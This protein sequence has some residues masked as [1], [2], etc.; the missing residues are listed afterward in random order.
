MRKSLFTC[1]LFLG[2][3]SSI[4]SQDLTFK[5]VSVEKFKYQKTNGVSN[6]SNEEDSF[7]ITRITFKNGFI[8]DKYFLPSQAIPYQTDTI[9]Q[10]TD[11]WLIKKNDQWQSYFSKSDFLLKRPWKLFTE[12]DCLI[13]TP[14]STQFQEGEPIYI[15]S[16]KY[17]QDLGNNLNSKIYFTITRGIIKMVLK[18]GSVYALTSR[19][20]SQ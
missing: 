13:Y 19:T 8:I 2:V 18:N 14:I 9:L 11:K 20:L 4:N 5:V 6:I 3:L 1:F 7:F 17:C 16:K 12:Q 10:L 15:F